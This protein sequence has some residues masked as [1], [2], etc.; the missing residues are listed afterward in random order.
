MNSPEAATNLRSP[1]CSPVFGCAC[2]WSPRSDQGRPWPPH[3]LALATPRHS[4]SSWPPLSTAGTADHASPKTF[5]PLQ[6]RCYFPRRFLRDGLEDE[7]DDEVLSSH[8][9]YH[10]SATQ[11]PCGHLNAHDE[12]RCHR[13]EAFASAP[14]YHPAPFDPCK[15]KSTFAPFYD[16]SEQHGCTAKSE[17]GPGQP[18]ED[19]PYI[20]TPQHLQ[21]DEPP[22]NC[23]G[24]PNILVLAK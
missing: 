20:P 6:T 11:N 12:L 14:S 13:V 16:Q 21:G 4:P 5:A 2:P 10:D 17:P 8:S 22:Q 19:N 7:E 1:N 24:S 23:S 15:K 3:P 9:L 18:T